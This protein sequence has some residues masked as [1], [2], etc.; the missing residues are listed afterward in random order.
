M[1]PRVAEFEREFAS[2][3]GTAPPLAVA[4]GTVALHAA[5]V[6][7]AR[8]GD[9]V[10]FPSLKFVATTNVIVPRERAGFL[11]RRGRG[12]LNLVPRD[13]EAALSPWTGP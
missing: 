1:G 5:L 9:E 6:A 4:N 3:C 7:G 12:G 13:L 11:R 2:L 8:P 10:V